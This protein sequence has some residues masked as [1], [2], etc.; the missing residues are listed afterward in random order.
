MIILYILFGLY[1]AFLLVVGITWARIPVV[2]SSNSIPSTQISIL[3]AARNEADNILSVLSDFQAQTYPS[4]LYEVIV[5]DDHSEDKT[6]KLVREFQENSPMKLKLLTL[7]EFET[8]K[9]SAINLGVSNA[10]GKLIVTTDADCRMGES[11]LEILEGFYREKDLKMITGPVALTAIDR[12]FEK[13][14]QIEFAS[15]TGTGACSLQL[16]IASMCNGANLAYEKSVFE[17]VDGFAGNEQVASGDDEF[18]YHKV[19]A[20]YPSKVAFLKNSGAIVYTAA[21]ET[22]GEFMQQRRRWASKWNYYNSVWPKVLAV[23]VFAANFGMALSVFI[24]P[25]VNSNHIWNLSSFMLLK[26]ILE[27]VVLR[28]IIRFNKTEFSLSAFVVLQ[29]IYPLY[30]SYFAINSKSG[31]YL[32]KGRKQY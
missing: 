12:L 15:L 23:F 10:A 7:G 24:L 16:G 3:I 13:M 29:L 18:L 32:W 11:Y 19:A 2:K 8:G 31:S 17:E 30:V 14:Q 22:L 5:I 20:L 9:K 28:E 21:R 4:D 26:L 25:F 6:T 1:I 27:F